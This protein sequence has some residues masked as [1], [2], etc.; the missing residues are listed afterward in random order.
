[1]DI[2]DLKGRIVEKEIMLEVKY[3]DFELNT[4]GIVKDINEFE[5]GIK[6]FLENKT[7]VYTTFDYLIEDEDTIFFMERI[8]DNQELILA[9]LKILD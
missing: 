8:S 7:S 6:I 9:M 5:E 1:M 3:D 4:V 2:K